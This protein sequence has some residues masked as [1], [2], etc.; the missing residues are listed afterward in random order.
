MATAKKTT[1]KKPA[2]VKP[3]PA[4]APA[5]N[6]EEDAAPVVTQDSMKQIM[7]LVSNQVAL[8]KR[9]AKGVA[10]LE[11]L[12]NQLKLITDKQLPDLFQQLGLKEFTLA[13]G[14]KVLMDQQV[15]PNISEANKAAAHAWLR[16]NKFDSLI[17]S[18]C[19]ISFG[20][21]DDKKAAALIAFLTKKGYTS[22][23]LKESVHPQ[24]LGAFVREQLA[25]GKA[26]PDSIGINPVTRAKLKFPK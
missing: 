11:D 18:K 15:Y 14:T 8:E 22:Y 13:D 12:G 20:K 23:T 7:D 1:A 24:T 6:L 26:L 19:D 16:K 5:I 25:A 3:K 10:L 17:K 21:G 9:I 2:L 4:T